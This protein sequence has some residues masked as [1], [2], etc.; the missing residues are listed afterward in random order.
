MPINFAL[1]E[2]KDWKPGE[3]GVI[4]NDDVDF[5]FSQYCRYPEAKHAFVYMNSFSLFEKEKENLLNI[6]RML[7]YKITP[8]PDY[9][10]FW[11]NQMKPSDRLVTSAKINGLENIEWLQCGRKY[12]IGRLKN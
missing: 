2:L 6:K 8:L 4:F 12:W 1:K 9:Y 5:A 11:V 3:N 10:E 7:N